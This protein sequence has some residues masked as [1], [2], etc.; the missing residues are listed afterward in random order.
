MFLPPQQLVLFDQDK[1]EFDNES[2][3]LVLEVSSEALSQIPAA[4]SLCLELS[5]LLILVMDVSEPGGVWGKISGFS[6]NILRRV[7]YRF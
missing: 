5:K 7:W 3:L 4:S 6:S 1:L 2:C